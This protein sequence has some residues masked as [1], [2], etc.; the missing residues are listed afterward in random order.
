[1]ALEAARLSI[2]K[3]ASFWADANP[4]DR[5]IMSAKA[6]YLATNA[7]IMVTEM[8]IQTVGGRSIV[9]GNPLGRLFRDVRTCTL[10]PP[11]SDRQMEIIGR[12]ELGVDNPGDDMLARLTHFV[13]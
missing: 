8:A 12:A 11:N 6:K 7:A 1:M 2:Y 5:A 10:M 9:A 3:A 13:S 4:Y